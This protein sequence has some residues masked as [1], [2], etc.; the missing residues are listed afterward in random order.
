M[1]KSLCFISYF[2]LCFTENLDCK[3]L[4]FNVSNQKR[5]ESGLLTDTYEKEVECTDKDGKLMTEIVKVIQISVHQEAAI[6]AAKQALCA[7]TINQLMSTKNFNAENFVSNTLKNGGMNA[8]MAFETSV[9]SEQLKNLTGSE[10]MGR[11]AG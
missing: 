8:L 9:V 7:A 3:S 10:L 1:R 2:V 11:H 6:S 4:E 5:V